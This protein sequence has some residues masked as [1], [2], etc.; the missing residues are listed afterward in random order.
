MDG[1]ALFRV[2]TEAR[3]RVLK[4][5]SDTCLHN[6]E[7]GGYAYNNTNTLLTQFE[8]VIER[9]FNED[10]ADGMKGLAINVSNVLNNYKST[11]H[12][13]KRDVLTES[14]A[15]AKLS[16]TDDSTVK[17]DI[18]NNSNAQDEADRQNVFCLAAIGVKE[19]IAEGITKI[20]GRDITNPI[21]KTMHNS[22]FK[23]VDQ[24]Q[25]HQLFTAITE[26]AEIPESSNIRI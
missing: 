7:V 16:S 10:S 5:M 24:F 11:V 8:R 20:V 15:A 4:E 19:G 25:I 21:L 23:S 3:N 1:G 18:A 17:P 2:R 9:H 26:G 12:I 14:R 6:N 22:D 13:K